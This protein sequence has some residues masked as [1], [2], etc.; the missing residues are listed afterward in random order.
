MGVARHQQ[1]PARYGT[2]RLANK[3]TAHDAARQISRISHIAYIVYMESHIKTCKRIKLRATEEW[4][5]MLTLGSR[6]LCV[7]A[8]PTPQLPCLLNYNTIRSQIGEGEKE[9]VIFFNMG[10]NRKLCLRERGTNVSC[11]WETID[12]SYF[13][14]TNTIVEA[15]HKIEWKCWNRESIFWCL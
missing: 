11:P 5:A 7:P 9:R 4:R 12:G 3:Q 2:H 13:W 1:Q 14:T 8:P 15:I 6:G 10:W